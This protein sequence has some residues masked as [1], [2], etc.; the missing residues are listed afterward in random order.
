[1][2]K[3][4]ERWLF[5]RYSLYEVNNAAHFATFSQYT[6]WLNAMEDNFD[7]NEFKIRTVIEYDK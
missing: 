3:E 2:K 5:V 6:N 7:E 1:M 4:I